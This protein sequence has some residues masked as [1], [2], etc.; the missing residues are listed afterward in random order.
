VL[1]L[2]SVNNIVIPPART[3]KE[4]NNKTAVIK[5]AHTKSGNLCIDNP[6]ARML[7][8]V[9][10]KLIAPKIEDIPDK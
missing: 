6:I 10:I 5:T 1:K 7:K 2:R 3:G 9:A 4:S 8:I